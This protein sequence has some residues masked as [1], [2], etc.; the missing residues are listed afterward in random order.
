[1]RNGGPSNTLSLPFSLSSY[2]CFLF[3][4]LPSLFSL[5]GYYSSRF[6]SACC[7][8]SSRCSRGSAASVGCAGC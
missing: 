1:M 6:G 8:T 4:R 5:L 3:L 2:V 7:T